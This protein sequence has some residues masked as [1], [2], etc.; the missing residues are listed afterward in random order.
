MRRVVESISRGLLLIVLGVIFFLI[1]F[2][3]LSWG[4]WMNVAE[5]WPLLLILGGIA[6]FF[7]KRIPMSSVL[8]IFLIFL[9]GYSMVFGT[10]NFDPFRSNFYWN[11]SNEARSSSGS[12]VLDTPLPAGVN[13]ADVELRLGGAK[14]QIQGVSDDNNLA[15]GDYD[16]GGG[17]VTSNPEFKTEHTG[18][19]AKVMLSAEKR[20]GPGKSELNLSLTDKVEYSFDI[21][22][23]AING[24]LDLSKLR[25]KDFNLDTGASDLTLQFGD[26]G[27]A[28]KGEINGAASQIT[29]VIPQEVGV[30]LQASSVINKSNFAEAGLVKDGDNDWIS[31]GYENAK[32]K[33]DMHI[34]MA[35]GSVELQ[36][37]AGGQVK[38]TH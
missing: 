13:K 24:D 10:N 15:L 6:L 7:G 33:V 3:V 11:N 28:T 38:S 5:L 34:S 36:R 19:K 2:G 21:K 20:N 14:M 18:E 16:W 26:T 23:G 1:N 30:R 12:V 32:S 22:V 17:F 4:F 29:L 25:V 9:V 37:Q 31:P 27:G 8:V 35:V